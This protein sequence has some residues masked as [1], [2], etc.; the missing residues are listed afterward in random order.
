MH[1]TC[2]TTICRAYCGD[3]KFNLR[4]SHSLPPLI[5]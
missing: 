1:G 4:Y 2:P 3:E 5:K